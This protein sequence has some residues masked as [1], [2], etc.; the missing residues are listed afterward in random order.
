MPEIV[1]IQRESSILFQRRVLERV[2]FVRLLRSTSSNSTAVL[3][4]HKRDHVAL[5]IFIRKKENLFFQ[6]SHRS[7]QAFFPSKVS[8]DNRDGR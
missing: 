3:L 8:S 7:F 4:A 5:I 6:I 1:R 2:A